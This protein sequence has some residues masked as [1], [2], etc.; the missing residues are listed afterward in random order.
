M[1]VVKEGESPLEPGVV[2]GMGEHEAQDDPLDSRRVGT[3]VLP[4]L[5]VDVV[6]D[7]G[8]L[9]NGRIGDTGV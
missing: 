5:E 3:S 2:F 7:L 1:E 8:H 6:D 4:V 9:L